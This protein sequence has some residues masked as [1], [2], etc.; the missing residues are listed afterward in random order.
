VSIDGIAH[1]TYDG[2]QKIAAPEPKTKSVY[3]RAREA[4]FAACHRGRLMMSIPLRLDDPDVLISAALD[5]GE[6]AEKG[7]EEYRIRL[8]GVL[9]ILEGANQPRPDAEGLL[10]FVAN[11]LTFN[12]AWKLRDKLN[13][14]EKRAE[15]AEKDLWA[16]RRYAHRI[17]LDY[18][19]R[20]KAEDRAIAAERERDEVRKEL[21]EAL[22]LL[23]PARPEDGLLPAIRDVMQRLAL[24][25]AREYVDPTND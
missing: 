1:V 17:E 21:A 14:A 18:E 24:A 15:E 5:A 12:A 11:C 19:S 22:A 2:L 25:K 10:P 13:A 6:A 8:A 23:K 7:F 4:L 16:V 3:E 9:T 20:N